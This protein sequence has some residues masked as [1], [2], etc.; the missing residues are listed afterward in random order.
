[1]NHEVHEEHKDLLVL[2]FV[3]F[4][5]FVVKPFVVRASRIEWGYF[6]GGA[7]AGAAGGVTGSMRSTAPA[8]SSVST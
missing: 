7:A 4:V 1:M 2:S 8:F 5:F 3:S 6:A